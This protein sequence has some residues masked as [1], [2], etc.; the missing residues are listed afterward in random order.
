MLREVDW[1]S[2]SFLLIFMFLVASSFDGLKC[3]VADFPHMKRFNVQSKNTESALQGD[4]LI[5]CHSPSGSFICVTKLFNC[6]L[7]R[8]LPLIIANRPKNFFDMKQ[9][10]I[11]V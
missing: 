3:A 7:R 8:L 4:W 9:V 11:L 1:R 10:N 6:T 2:S 5:S